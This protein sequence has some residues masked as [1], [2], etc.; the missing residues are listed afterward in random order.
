M[1]FDGDPGVA[2]PR[3]AVAHRR[4]HGHHGVR[5]VGAV[6]D[7][8]PEGRARSRHG[9]RSAGSGRPG[10][11][12]RPTGSAGSPDAVGVPVSSICG[13]TDICTAFIGSSPL[14]EVRAGEIGGRLL[15]CAVEAFT[16][17]GTVVPA[18]RHRRA[19][20]HATDA[21]DAGRVLGRRRRLEVP[22]RVLRGLP[23]RVAPRR[24]GDVHRRRHVHRHRSLRRDAQP[25]RRAP[26]HERLL[27]GRRGFCR[28]SPTASSCTSRTT[29]T[30]AGWA[31]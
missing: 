2:R 25:R 7:G 19:R 23:R 28:R 5:R 10:R 26:R 1:L 12:C 11:R 29:A 9:A 18:R 21:V 31:S 27:L 20:D 22:R 16:P 13:G 15:G 4:G 14:Q 17:D 6:P 30:P 8:V 24:L 3:R